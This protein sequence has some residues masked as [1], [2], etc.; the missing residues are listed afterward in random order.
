MLELRNLFST[1]EYPQCGDCS[2]LSQSKPFYCKLDHNNGLLSNDI[3][4]LSE[5]F[6]SMY[7]EP[8]PFRSRELELIQSILPEDMRRRT[9]YSA[10]IKCPGVK[11]GDMSPGNMNIC[12]EHLYE[13]LL[14]VRPK[15]VFVC[16]NLAMKMLI[17]KSGIADKR[18]SPFPFEHEEFK[19]TVVPIYHP[20]FV[21]AEPKHRYLFEIDI[22]NS[23]S[24]I[25]EKKAKSDFSY[26]ILDSEE[27]LFKLQPLYTT[28][29]P[30]ACD[31]ETTGYN[32]LKDRLNT[33]AFAHESGNYVIPLE[34]KD[35]LFMMPPWGVIQNV[36]SNPN[37]IKVFQNAKFDLKFLYSRGVQAVKVWDTKIMQHLVN[38]NTPKSLL[39]LVNMYFPEELE[40]NADS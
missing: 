3:L 2:I 20:Y 15:L 29:T 8:T 32:F 9:T 18:G 39:D 36:L 6:T 38:E 5:S 30:V 1:S 37:N 26:E 14:R 17:K 4:F 22:R 10:S 34:H 40:E 23:I 25:I 7:G 31:I 16:G 27:K 19:C 11:D 24:R 13:T 33:I 35:N 21:L 28:D 12:R